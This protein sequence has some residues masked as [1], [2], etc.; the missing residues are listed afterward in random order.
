[1]MEDFDPE[2]YESTYGTERYI[3]VGPIYL[4]ESSDNAYLYD[5]NGE[6]PYEVNISGSKDLSLN[7]AQARKIRDRL[8][9][10]LGDEK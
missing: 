1:M 3:T 8:N 6:Q 10:F 5:P 2:F 9:T 4:S 7:T